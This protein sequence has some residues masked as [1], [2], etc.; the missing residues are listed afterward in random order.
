MET[1]H[2]I[3]AVLKDEQGRV[4]INQ[5]PAG[6]PWAGYWEFPGGKL[7]PGETPLAALKRELHEELGITVHDARFWIHVSHAYPE[8][9]VELEVWRVQHYS[10]EPHARENQAL[11]WVRPKELPGRK[12]LPADRTIVMGL[13]FPLEMLVTPS[14]DSDQDQFLATLERSLEHGVEF[15]Q[16][17]APEL[18]LPDYTSLAR[19]VIVLCHRHGANV[20][21]NSEPELAEQLGADGVHLSSARLSR[22][23][24]KPLSEDFMVGASCH[25]EN[26]IRQSQICG[27]DYI[28]LGPVFAT[29]S[30][31]QAAT[32]GWEGFA[33]LASLSLSPAYAIG[34]MRP[35]HLKRVRGFGA[36]GIAAMRGLW[37]DYSFTAS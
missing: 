16:L 25:D 21:L 23:T 24:R 3:A 15:V 27:L 2:V 36:H 1:I 29:L 18:S 11:V 5:R 8:R 13:C 22:M 9:H 7:E 6:K 32:L 28:I 19:E 4:L 17:R 31:P 37:N 14:P 12:L 34:G 20:V 26:E 30:H 35:E 33:R 10:G